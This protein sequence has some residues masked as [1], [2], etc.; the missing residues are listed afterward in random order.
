M[1]HTYQIGRVG[2]LYGAQE[3][4][5]GASA[6]LAATDAVRHLGLK[7]N[8]NPRNRVNSPE[9]HAH[10]SQIYRF[11]R[12][13][14][15]D[16][17]VN[18]ILYPSG[19][20]NTVPDVDFMLEAF[21]GSKTNVTLATTIAVGG[22]GTTTADTLTSA[23][24]LAVGDAIAITHQDGNIY[25][26]FITAVNTGTGV[27]TWA[28]ALPSALTDGQA[29]KGC[30]TYKL[31]T[32]LLA[33]AS[34]NWAHYLT[35]H[36]YEMNGCA[37]ESLKIMV[38]ANNEIMFEA[39]GPAQKRTRNAQTDP[40]T[41]TTAGTTP[42]S[43]LTGYLRVDGSAEEFLKA[44]FELKNGLKLDNVAFGTAQAQAMY[45]AGK[46]SVTAALDTMVSNDVTIL[47]AAEA[48]N[49]VAAMVQ[50]G[51]TQGSIWAMYAPKLELDTPDD[52]NNEEE[53]QHAYKGIC[54]GTSGNDEFYL[55]VA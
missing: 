55:A 28:P 3:A 44:S 26:R 7:F 29:V 36:S 40:A 35:S 11:N 25:V 39:S 22:A 38:D 6:A 51:F 2:R 1:S 33:T 37:P 31:T 27:T 21:F 20:L 53:M 16:W 5:Y 47:D 8:Q 15:A 52:P 9:R 30:L 50:C 49:D 43:G 24:G 48:S 46:R 18:G 23:A 41:F 12:R 4:S 19:T 13:K 17:M 42:P 32:A 45:R 54:K 10:P 34:L 14:T